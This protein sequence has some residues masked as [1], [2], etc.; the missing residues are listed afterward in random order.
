ML[1]FLSDQN[2]SSQISGSYHNVLQGISIN[3][4]S[5]RNIRTK[6]GE[7]QKSSQLNNR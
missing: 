4:V 6:Y 1:R 5:I 7:K 2:S 3:S